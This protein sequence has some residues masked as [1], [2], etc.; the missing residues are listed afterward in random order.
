MIIYDHMSSSVIVPGYVT[1]RA[2]RRMAPAGSTV[3]GWPGRLV[4]AIAL[5]PP[6]CYGRV[7]ELTSEEPTTYFRGQRQK[8]GP[9]YVSWWEVAY[10]LRPAGSGCYC[11]VCVSHVLV[12]SVVGGRATSQAQGETS[13]RWGKP[14]YLFMARIYTLYD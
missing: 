6:W 11:L 9:E 4:P 13:L 7:C 12:V 1:K 2:G 8:L 14:H 5:P 3:H 10:I